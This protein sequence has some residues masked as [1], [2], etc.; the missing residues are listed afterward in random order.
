MMRSR[1]IVLGLLA[2]AVVCAVMFIFA[3]SATAG[4]GCRGWRVSYYPASVH[5]YGAWRPYSYSHYAAPAYSYSAYRPYY[6]GSWYGYGGY[7]CGGCY[8]P[9]YAPRFSY[10]GCY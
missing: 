9:Y 10:Y 1:K 7:G 6:Y 4:C 2:V 5:Y 3:D 8:S